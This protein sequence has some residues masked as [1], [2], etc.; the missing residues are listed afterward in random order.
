MRLNAPRKALIDTRD[1]P[2]ESN[3]QFILKRLTSSFP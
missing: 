2:T 1:L 3:Q